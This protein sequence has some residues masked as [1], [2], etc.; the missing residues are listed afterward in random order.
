MRRTSLSV[1]VPFIVAAPLLGAALA[2]SSLT[3]PPTPE[4]VTVDNAQVTAPAKTAPATALSAQM[5]ASA[6]SALAAA[7]N[8]PSA[9]PAQQQQGDAKLQIQDIS[10]G[11]GKEAKAGQ[12]VSVH[13]TGR[14]V[15][16]K[17]FD[18]SR[19]RNKPFDFPLGQG[20]VIKGWDQGL[21]GMKVG[22][23]R[24]LTIPP[25]LAY[26]ERGSPPVI[27]PNSTLVFDVELL[28]VK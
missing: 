6:A 13:Y 26:G 9:A 23:K 25:S 12:T 28:D 24:K 10:V 2:C 4:P 7:R 1:A 16:G 21:L 5:I 17:E 3:S 18:S 20:R 11:K 8:A 14:L 27:P 22:G 19:T 15:D